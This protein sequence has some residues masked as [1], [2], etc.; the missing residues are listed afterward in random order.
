[1]NVRIVYRG[2]G[3]EILISILRGDVS[4]KAIGEH[5]EIAHIGSAIDARLSRCL[6]GDTTIERTVGGGFFGIEFGERD[7]ADA[8]DLIGHFPIHSV[9]CLHLE[10]EANGLAERKGV[11]DETHKLIVGVHV[12]A[13]L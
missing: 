1:M 2:E 4:I 10:R 11:G 9:R 6:E 7:A 12:A 8:I 5:E 3:V 13:V